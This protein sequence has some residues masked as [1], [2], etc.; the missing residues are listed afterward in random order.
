[1]DSDPYLPGISG[2]SI[3]RPT[4]AFAVSGLCLGV[5]SEKSDRLHDRAPIERTK[6][7]ELVVREPRNLDLVERHRQARRRDSGSRAADLSANGRKWCLQ[8]RLSAT[9]IRYPFDGD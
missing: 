4:K 8:W 6:L 3:H 2:Q 5:M 1:M 9:A 7:L